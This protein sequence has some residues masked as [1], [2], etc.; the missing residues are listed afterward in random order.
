MDEPIQVRVS[1]DNLDAL[2]QLSDQVSRVLRSVKGYQ[3]HDDLGVRM[4]NLRIDIDQDRANSLGIGNNQ[5]GQVS[6][7]AFAGLKV[8]E[9]RDGDRLIPVVIRLRVEDRN[10]AEKIRTLYVQNVNH[11]EVPL[12]SFALLSIQPEFVTI[13]HYNQLRAVTVKAYPPFGELTA[14]VLERARPGLAAIKLPPGYNLS[15]DGEDKEL[16]QNQSEMG[17]VMKV[18]LALI[19]LV[20]VIQFNSVVKSIAVML[21]VPLGI[22]GAFLGLALTHSP[23]GFMAL[24]GIV[25]LAGIIVSHIIVL[26]DFIEEARAAGMPLEQALVQ[27]GLARL[28]PV[29]VTVLATVGGLLPLFF[30]GGALWHP[31]TAVHIFGLLF[32]TSLTL[33]LLPVIYYVFSAKL[34]LIK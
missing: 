29:L 6:Q 8:T 16:R 33:I 13:P 14:A 21:T 17:V 9:L 19:T 10:E 32:A 23:L 11:K 27:A 7:A 3:V 22:I 20:M 30:T 25:S 34:K 24:L 12:E 4:P 15:F 1:G 5:I 28:R 26:S 2:A 18:S 31:L